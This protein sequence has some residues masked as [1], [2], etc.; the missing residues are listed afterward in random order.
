[1]KKMGWRGGGAKG[2]GMERERG[3]KGSEGVEREKQR[4]WESGE[5]VERQRNFTQAK[6]TRKE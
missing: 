4:E 1:M 5:E 2:V 3:W 6:G